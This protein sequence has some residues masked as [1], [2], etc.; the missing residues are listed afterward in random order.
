MGHEVLVLSV[1]L[2]LLVQENKANTVR[3]QASIYREKQS[4]Y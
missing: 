4:S 3:K 1:P 2:F